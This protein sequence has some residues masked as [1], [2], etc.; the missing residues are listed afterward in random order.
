MMTADLVD[1]SAT[2]HCQV[3]VEASKIVWTCGSEDVWCGTTSGVAEDKGRDDG[4]G[5]SMGT[6][7]C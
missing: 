1:G 5:S 2:I 4:C 3:P 7:R 6:A